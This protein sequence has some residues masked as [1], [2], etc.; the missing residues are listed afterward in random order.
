MAL[1]KVCQEIS[2]VDVKKL[3][4][5]VHD[6]AVEIVIGGSRF[7]RE[8][9]C[10]AILGAGGDGGCLQD[11][12][13]RVIEEARAMHPLGT[14]FVGF[15]EKELGYWLNESF[16]E[17]CRASFE[18]SPSPVPLEGQF[19]SGREADFAAML[20]RELH[21]DSC[22]RRGV[23][24]DNET[25]WNGLDN[26]TRMAFSRKAWDLFKSFK[27]LGYAIDGSHNFLNFRKAPDVDRDVL[28]DK[29][30]RQMHEVKESSVGG[31]HDIADH[32]PFERLPESSRLEFRS[33][34]ETMLRLMDRKGLRPVMQADISKKAKASNNISRLN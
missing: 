13:S 10:F 18:Y 33:E 20:G 14:E 32:V 1:R 11:I 29:L 22:G 28:I 17:S 21:S 15:F 26:D 25:E 30:S 2:S 16:F 23:I 12:R 8:D 9:L 24:G 5:I 34:V 3:D 6:L 31:L 27:A 4:S 19:L 7:D